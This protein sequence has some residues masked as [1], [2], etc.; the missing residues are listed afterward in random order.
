MSI[1]YLLTFHWTKPLIF[2]LIVCI[3]MMRI[4][5]RSLRMFFV[6]CLPWP[7]KNRFLSLI[8]KLYKEIDG[9]A[10]ES[11]LGPALANIFMY[12]FENKWLKDC[13]HSLKPV[14]IDSMLMIY[15]YCFP[16]W[17]KQKKLEKE[18]DSRL[19]FSDINIIH[20]KGKFV[21]NGH[22]KKDLQ[23]YLY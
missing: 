19:S 13:P 16:L 23:W 22:K 20:E 12:R 15:L 18:N 11:L 7:P 3:K 2:A 14:F 1:P 10:L 17:I 9:V 21:T 4:V 6:I 8:K 5:L